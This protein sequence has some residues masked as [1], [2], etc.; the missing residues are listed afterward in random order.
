MLKGDAAVFAVSD[1][2]A[3]LAYYRDALGFSVEFRWGEPVS[4]ACLCRD[5]VALH[6]ASQILAKRQPGQGAL[7]IFVSDVDAIH[8]EIAAKGARVVKPPK[9][10]DYGMRDFDVRDLDGNQITYGMPSKGA[11]Q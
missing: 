9:D 4:Y 5:N 6:L 10:Y 7:C 1:L 2:E 3:S 11:G 8:E